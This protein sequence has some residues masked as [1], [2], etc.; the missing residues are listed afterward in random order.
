[1]KI[2]VE[3][4]QADLKGS[5]I[6]KIIPEVSIAPIMPSVPVCVSMA[7]VWCTLPRCIQYQCIQ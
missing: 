5:N 1:M 6:A 3:K 2:D 7:S 4:A